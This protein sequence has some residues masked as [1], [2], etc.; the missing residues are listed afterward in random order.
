[1]R[2]L[3]LIAA[4]SDAARASWHRARKS[5]LPSGRG[6]GGAEQRRAYA[7]EMADA[8]VRT[9]VHDAVQTITLDS[10]S[11]RNALSA[12]LLTELGGALELAAVDPDVRVVVLT[13]TGTVFCAGAD[14]NDPP[15]ND[16]NA[17]FGLPA[18]LQAIT[19]CPKPVVGRINGHVRAGGLGL[20]AACDIAVA[21][22]DASF[23]FSEVRVGVAPAIIAVVCQ[24]LMRPR[25]FARY[26]LTGASFAAADAVAA[27]LLT[28]A[29]PPDDLDAATDRIVG[30]CLTGAPE[31]IARTK[32]LGH[33]LPQLSLA[34]QFAVAADV[35]ASQFQSA[36]A[37]EGIAAFR[38]KRPPKWSR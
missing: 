2:S 15:G 32:A 23:A 6:R 13:G 21:P 19:G 29:V 30:E 4:A 18:V 38:E 36:E 28:L 37:I 31:A 16:P 20:V 26:T 34:E 25:D 9:H 10:P 27:G 3:Q 22:A 1:V 8:L 17:P 14:L 5:L 12:R 7:A 11:N 33:Q 24:P 35:S